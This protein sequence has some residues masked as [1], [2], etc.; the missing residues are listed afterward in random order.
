MTIVGVSFCVLGGALGE[1]QF[2]GSGNFGS[3][4]LGWTSCLAWAHEASDA[5]FMFTDS[6]F[7]F[8]TEVTS[9]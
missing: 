8:Q 3:W 4:D 5:S 9:Y 1:E 2:S 6:S 7:L